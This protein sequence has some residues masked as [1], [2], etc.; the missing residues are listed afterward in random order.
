MD[1]EI[2]FQNRIANSKHVW[3]CTEAA[4]MEVVELTGHEY[5][6]GFDVAYVK[7]NLD[8]VDRVLQRIKGRFGLSENQLEIRLMRKLPR[9][10]VRIYDI[11]AVPLST[12]EAGYVQVIY[13][14][15][16]GKGDL[17]R[18]YRA[19]SAKARFAAEILASGECFPPV[20]TFVAAGAKTFG[21]R[22]VGNHPIPITLPTFRDCP[23]H[24]GRPGIYGDWSLWTPGEGQRA[25]GRLGKSDSELEILA[26]WSPAI[27]AE[28]MVTN[29]S[30]F[31]GIL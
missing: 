19:R 11:W 25:V 2:R 7:G 3:D 17:V 27:V 1:L 31:D 16:D 24:F 30:P 13:R 8:V 4:L 28:R 10:R 9:V 22:H 6:E 12:G 21:W 18:V 5:T 26:T 23:S 14:D 29:R 20:F 15:P